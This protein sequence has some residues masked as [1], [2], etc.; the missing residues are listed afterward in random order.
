MSTRTPYD[1]LERMQD[2]AVDEIQVA[3][4]VE[5]D[6]LGRAVRQAQ[7]IDAEITAA[8]ASLLDDPLMDAAPFLR[9]TRVRRA[10]AAAEQTAL[11]ANVAR[12]RDEAMIAF[13]ALSAT[14]EAVSGF[15]TATMRAALGAEQAMLDDLSATAHHRT[16]SRS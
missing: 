7:A 9:A 10:A 12:L 4:G 15:R 16:R 5:L 2:R 8:R 1:A 14:R 11:D 3:I 6:Q 13:S